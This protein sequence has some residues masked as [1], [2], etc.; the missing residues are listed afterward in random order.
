[1]RTST[2]GVLLP[3]P[4]R[5]V[6]IFPPG[7]GRG[8]RAVLLTAVVLLLG[9][10]AIA[11]GG[12]WAAA[13]V[14]I[15][16]LTAGASLLTPVLARR[17]RPREGF[18]AVEAPVL[19]LLLSTL[20]FR[21][22]GAGDIEENPLDPAGLFR[23]GALAAALS[24]AGLAFLSAQGTGRTSERAGARTLPSRPFRL[25]TMYAA[26]V[27]VGVVVSPFPFL[28]VF[29]AIDLAGGLL[30]L[31]AAVR[32]VGPEATERIEPILYWF[33]VALLLSV[34]IGVVAFPGEAVTR[35]AS[36][37]PF[38]VRGV[39]PHQPENGVG[40]QG[41]ILAV[42][43]LGRFF[44]PRIEGAPRRTVSLMI[45]GLGLISLFAAQYRTGYIAVAIGVFILLAFR[46]R[47]LLAVLAI[48]AVG[49]AL[50]WGRVIAD[51]AQPLLLRGESFDAAAKLS[52]RVDWWGHAI[53]VWREAPLT[54][55]G[56]LTATRY[57]VL[58]PIGLDATSTIH[59]T[60]IEALVGTGAIGTVLLAAFFL[61]MLGRS[62]GEAIQPT[63]RIVPL[64]VV[65]VIGVRSIT[66]STFEA[67]GRTTLIMLTMALVLNDLRRRTSDAHVPD[68]RQVPQPA[69]A[70][71]R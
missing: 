42:W 49:G 55:Q 2:P 56:L 33:S 5:R 22:R 12:L 14:G 36:P 21:I 60:W 45:A 9:T 16:G 7:G 54:G 65:S 34:W 18:L 26:W 48:L 47:N 52:S 53:P 62:L 20:V 39:I 67:S 43:S 4:K 32:T 13:A 40:T 57:K 10:A 3:A 59:S 51:E 24:L 70:V 58:A 1:M 6:H 50:L 68:D 46:G 61:V 23:L 69:Q 44:S 37:I 66:G 8:L 29:H 71:D 19:L 31:H 25:Y 63:G 30:V 15:V 35:V 38:Q 41:A 64:L 27:F 11:A 28:T 17:I